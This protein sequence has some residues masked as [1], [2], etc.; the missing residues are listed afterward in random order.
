MDHSIMR[1][2]KAWLCLTALAVSVSLAGCGGDQGPPPAVVGSATL[3]A[4][5]GTVDGPD[6]TQLVVAPD[7]LSG[8]VSFRLARDASGAPPLE[9]LNAVSP[10]YAVTPH[11]Q[12]F[13]ADALFSIP[14]SAVQLPA[15]ATPVLLK[16]E[17]GGKWRVMRNAVPGSDRLAADV[18]DL[19]YFVVGTCAAVPAAS[20]TIGA[21]GCPTDHALRL[22]LLDGNSAVQ[23][24]RGPNGVQLP[25]AYVTDTPRTLDFVVDW[26][27]PDSPRVDA[28]S[29]LGTNGAFNPNS[30]DVSGGSFSRRFS[31]TIDPAQVA[32]AGGPHGRLL[33]IT[34]SAS[35]A[36]TAFRVG[37]GNVPTGFEFVTDIP[38]LV[39]YSGI[40]PTLVQQPTP[41]SLS[42]VENN[43]FTLSALA[44]GPGISYQWRYFENAQ[45]TQPIPAEGVN[46]QPGYTSPPAPLG[47]NGRR[48]QVQVCT[49]AGTPVVTRCGSS[50]LVDLSVGAMPVAA[51]FTSQPTSAD[52]LEAEGTAFAAAVRGTPSPTL[53]WHIGVS[54]VVRPIIG[55]SCSGTPLADGAGS[56]VLAGATVSAAGTANLA[57]SAVP[58]AANGSVLALQLT[59]PG[60]ANAVWSDRVTLVVR[61][62]PVGAGFVGSGLQSPRE[63]QENGSVE[64]SAALVG[65]QPIDYFWSIDGTLVQPGTLTAGRCMGAV[66]ALPAAGVLR[67]S[68]VPLGCNAAVIALGVQNTATPAGTRPTAT[69]LLNVNA[70]PVAP[71]VAVQLQP[72][73]VQEGQSATLNLAYGG[74]LPIS[75]T[76][77]RFVS[78]Q[79]VDAGSTGSAACASPCAISTPVLQVADNGAQYR[80]RL[81]NATGSLLSDAVSVTVNMLRLPQFSTQPAAVAVDAGQTASFGFA[82]GNDTG[83]FSYQWLA[84]G[85]PLADGSNNA[86]LPGAMVGGASGNGNAGTLVLSSVPLDANGANLSVRVQRTAGT[87]HT[88]ATSAPARLTVNTGIPADGLTATQVVAGQ[89]WSLVLRPDRTVWGWGSLHRNDGQVQIANMNPALQATRPVRMYPA[90]LSDVRQIAGWSN[91]FW[92]LTGEPGSAA[93]R[94]LHWGDARSGGD[95]RG[96]DGQ[97]GIT[98]A[99]QQ[100]RYNEAAP[101]VV[102]ERPGNTPQPVDRVC[103]IAGG[104]ARL[105]MIRAIDTNGLTTSCAAGAAKSVWLVGSL[106]QIDDSALGVAL[107]VPGLPSSLAAG[108]SPR[109]VFATAPQGLGGSPYTIVLDDGRVYAFGSNYYDGL[110]LGNANAWFGGVGGPVAL[111]GAWGTVRAT[112]GGG[113]FGNFYALRADGS[114]VTG[115]YSSAGSMGLGPVADNQNLPGPLPVLAETCTAL[116][117]AGVLNGVTAV[118][119]SAANVTLAL[120][121]GR[122]LAWGAA[123]QPMLGNAARRDFPQPLANS[124]AGY[125]ALSASNIHALVIGPGNAVYSWGSDL[126]NALGRRVDSGAP[127]TVPGLVSIVP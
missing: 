74:S 62:R 40:S 48:Y 113:T 30:V 42:V 17:A 56:G 24:Q 88:Q 108:A 8:D 5:G 12:A 58:L 25:L 41:A 22:T 21:V 93:S 89:E 80:I 102:L 13:A 97:G 43:S 121:N 27:R 110:G 100:S 91:S 2:A 67:L 6:G 46:N 114:V 4:A 70:L 64:F 76:L 18:S 120:K 68:N 81:V 15:G 66:V 117:C 90:V 59:Q 45:S 28:V 35:Y 71:S 72:V 50:A 112:A 34:A 14:L 92:A 47:W 111:G 118:A 39:R 107:P 37:Q 125:T 122:I 44:T 95:G 98:G 33:R 83:S 54:C 26:V 20:W 94:V 115:G 55:V 53:R 96:R 109:A 101:V 86:A 87:Q 11:G 3:G 84:N 82:V 73:T 78:G 104:A 36:T 49:N 29:V 57:L 16:A 123:N 99:M 77:Q 79:W 126:R 69:A 119:G 116:P 85:Q 19:S 52:I 32:N 1:H 105:L 31:M 23:V 63:V 9:G 7:S 38:I 61:P 106:T 127:D 10:V 103:T 75:L 51:T 60:I 124:G 65:T